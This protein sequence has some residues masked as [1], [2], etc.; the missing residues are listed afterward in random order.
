M[1]I[2]NSIDYIDNNSANIFNTF[3]Y[4]VSNRKNSIRIFPDSTWIGA[5]SSHHEV[6]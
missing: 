2:N 3:Q 6:N 5:T 4:S 1:N